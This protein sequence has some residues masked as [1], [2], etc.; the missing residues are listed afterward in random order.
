MTDRNKQTS[1]IPPGIAGLLAYF[2][3]FFGG[4]FFLII[5]KENRLIRFHAVQSILLWIVFV[6]LAAIFSWIP[7]INLLLYLVILAIWIFAMYQALMER[8]YELPIIGE[9]SKRQA[10]GK[11][12]REEGTAEGKEKKKK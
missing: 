5:E 7:I 10:F 3:P 4:V 12:E 6:I 1:S 2:I 11:E 8:M 9:I